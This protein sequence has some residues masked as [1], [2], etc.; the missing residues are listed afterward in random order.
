MSERNRSA[1]L[2]F[3]RYLHFVLIH[4]QLK[5]VFDYLVWILNLPSVTQWIESKPAWTVPKPFNCTV[6]NSDQWLSKIMPVSDNG[7]SDRWSMQTFLFDVSARDL[8]CVIDLA[9]VIADFN[10]QRTECI[11]GVHSYCMAH[12]RAVTKFFETTAWDE[13]C[14]EISVFVTRTNLNEVGI[15]KVHQI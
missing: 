15:S 14:N 1:D 3:A 2:Q 7:I 10:I 12:T 11:P 4:A 5:L 13:I 8:I 9:F 6:R